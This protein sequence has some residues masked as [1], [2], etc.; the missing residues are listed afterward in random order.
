MIDGPKNRAYQQEDPRLP[1][2]SGA[3]EQ[4]TEYG[5]DNGNQFQQIFGIDAGNKSRCSKQTVETKT[6]IQGKEDRKLQFSR[7]C[8][9]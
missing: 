3:D 4:H 2:F 7:L 1:L 9:F 5:T 6:N 8:F